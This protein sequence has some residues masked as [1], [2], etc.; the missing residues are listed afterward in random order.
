MTL[1][2]KSF[3][4]S[5]S[6]G[7]TWLPTGRFLIWFLLG[8]IVTGV[9]AL[10]GM[11]LWFAILYYSVLGVITLRDAL[12]IRAIGSLQVTRESDSFFEIAEEHMV[13]LSIESDRLCALTLTL[14]DDVPAGFYTPQREQS[15]QLHGEKTGSLTYSL[16]SDRRGLYSFG[17]VHLRIRSPL[18]WIQRQQ[19]A[20]LAEEKRVYPLLKEVRRVRGGV[21]RKRSD[22]EGTYR[23][24]GIGHS[25]EV[26]HIREYVQGDDPRWINWKATAR[27]NKPA[28]N[29]PRAEQGQHVVIMLDCGRVM[30]ARDQEKSRL[31]RAIE[32]ALAFAAA[33]LTRG[34]YVSL[35]AFSNRIIKWIP[36]GKGDPQLKRLIEAV[37]GLDAAY[38]ES[39]YRM[40]MEHLAT[41]HK[42][43]ALVAIFTDAG[44]LTFAEELTQQMLLLRRRH[45]ILTVTM[46]DPRLQHELDRFP[47]EELDIYR[48]AVGEKMI[49]ERQERLHH[50]RR[51][52]VI[53]LDVPPGELSTS[54]IHAY[55]DLKN[56][57]L[58]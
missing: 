7:N 35:I 47:H 26:S 8:V 1:S 13:R 5:P 37:A 11:A 36:S 27:L 25:L 50:L 21:Y 39:G 53:V 46:Q 17:N 23:R 20:E 30:G 16:S 9:G 28:V 3:V 45:L 57:S 14:K 54:A 49:L 41:H 4:R 2:G 31:D 55:I 10:W 33:A 22:T 52:G 32:G 42:R 58:L 43:R 38:V 56:R 24:K 6:R 18:G 12:K 34:D 40:A 15:L 44:N 48:K 51:N 29:V 19:Q